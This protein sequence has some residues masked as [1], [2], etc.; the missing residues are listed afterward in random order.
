MKTN[1]IKYWGT[2]KL[3]YR[4]HNLAN[5]ML[6]LEWKNIRFHN[7]NCPYFDYTKCEV[8]ISREQCYKSLTLEGI[9]T[10]ELLERGIFDFAVNVCYN[11]ENEPE[12]IPE[13]KKILKS[14]LT[15]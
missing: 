6:I 10:D 3:R 1:E 2:N 15:Y 13:L 4:I 12:I 5:L 11:P 7:D 9:I 14:N 8:C